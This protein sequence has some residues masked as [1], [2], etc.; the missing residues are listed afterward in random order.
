MEGLKWERGDGE[1]WTLCLVFGMG[2]RDGD[3]VTGFVL[4]GAWGVAE[5]QDRV[6]LL[7]GIA[8]SSFDVG[9]RRNKGDGNLA[10]GPLRISIFD[11]IFG[12]FPEEGS[13]SL[14]AIS[15]IRP[16]YQDS[17]T[18]HLHRL[19][20]E[21]CHSGLD[22]VLAR[23]KGSTD[24]VPSP[25]ALL[26]VRRVPYLAGPNAARARWVWRQKSGDLPS[27]KGQAPSSKPRDPVQVQ[28]VPSNPANPMSS[29]GLLIRFGNRCCALF[30][31]TES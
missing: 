29:A 16:L 26:Q 30:L 24:T 23:P 13:F 18:S 2:S 31:L 22:A 7:A 19:A 9:L 15:N 27:P 6:H 3:V 1:F 14:G 5:C 12:G 4:V 17:L 25:L 10:G 21:P 20:R 8:S 11:R 28:T